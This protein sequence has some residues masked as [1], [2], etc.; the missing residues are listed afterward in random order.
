MP[1]LGIGAQFRATLAPVLTPL[2]SSVANAFGQ[3]VSY[4]G[5]GIPAW[6]RGFVFNNITAVLNGSAGEQLV[7][8]LTASFS[9]G[10]QN[11]FTTSPVA[12]SGKNYIFVS[13]VSTFQRAASKDGLWLTDIAMRMRSNAAN[14]GAAPQIQITLLPI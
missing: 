7:F 13:T 9:D 10:S 11:V 1:V 3:S 12:G 6:V 4:S 14:S 2:P 8:E 5:L